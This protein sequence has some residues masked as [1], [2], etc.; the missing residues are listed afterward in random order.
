MPNFNFWVQGQKFW[1]GSLQNLKNFKIHFWVQDQKLWNGH[2]R[3]EKFWIH[4]WVQDQKLWNGHPKIGKILNSLL[5]SGAK[6]VDMDTSRLDAFLQFI[7]E[8][9]IKPCGMDPSELG[10]KLSSFL[11]M[12]IYYFLYW[13]CRF[14]MSVMHLILEEAP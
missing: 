2:P 8:F 10:K 6:V 4:F 1:N 5:S 11:K 9:R 14:E 13:K 7:S 12:L 3:L